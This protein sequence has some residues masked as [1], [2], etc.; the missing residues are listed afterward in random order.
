MFACAPHIACG[1]CAIMRW[2]GLATFVVF[3]IAGCGNDDSTHEGISH[4]CELSID[5]TPVTGCP[6]P[7]ATPDNELHH[8]CPVTPGHTVIVSGTP[9]VVLAHA[10]TPTATPPPGPVQE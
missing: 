2:I 4:F 10:C 9:Y 3:T 5:G 8:G 1:S 6:T 7:T